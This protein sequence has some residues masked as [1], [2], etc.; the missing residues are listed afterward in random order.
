MKYADR[1]KKLRRGMEVNGILIASL[2]SS[3]P[4]VY[5]FTGIENYFESHFLLITKKNIA[6]LSYDMENAKKHRIK[7]VF[8]L[9]DMKV[10]DF[11]KK[12]NLHE[13]KVG[14]DG[15]V[16]YSFYSKLKEK[17]PRIKFV[18]MSEKIL[19]IRSV[20][21]EEEIKRISKV[22]AL[23]KKIIKENLYII[24]SGK[25]EKQIAKEFRKAII[26]NGNEE[27]FDL[28]AAADVNSSCI[29][30]KATDLKMKE[31][32]LLD[33][34]LKRK[35]YCSDVSKIFLIKRNNEIGRAIKTLRKLHSLLKKRIKIGVKA[36][37]IDKFAQD[38]LI[39][40]GYKK[41]QYGNFHALG[42]GVGIEVQECPLISIKSNEAFKENMVF[43]VE[44]AIYFRGKWGVRIE[45]VIW[46]KRS[47]A[48]NLTNFKH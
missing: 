46:L 38:F 40:A 45:D 27:A 23:T 8:N 1:I 34:G 26:N 4:N 16:A 15:K 47:G 39:K 12:F 17:L 25:S 28:I 32:L 37:S 20:K 19:K 42:H 14:I 2:K 9:A 44:P 18:D 13:K 36:A 3:F 43:T 22:C 7:N 48:K 41:E 31:L 33:V 5:Y 29:H 11:L 10:Y 30:H 24:K 21:D 6:L 35:N